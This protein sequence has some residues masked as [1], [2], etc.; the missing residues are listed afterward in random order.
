MFR[1]FLIATFVGIFSSIAYA[2]TSIDIGHPGD[3]SLPHNKD[4]W[5]LEA[6]KDVPGEYVFT[7]W[8]SDAMCSD[9]LEI[10]VV[11]EDGFRIFMTVKTDQY[12]DDEY[13]YIVPD[14]MQYM[15]YPPELRLPDG[16]EPGVIR[17]IQ[18]IV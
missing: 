13:I 16:A 11:A 5:T 10:G 14:D 1:N 9:N 15:A 4:R 2:Q 17:I 3:C 8:N 18:G 7:Y 6:N 12:S